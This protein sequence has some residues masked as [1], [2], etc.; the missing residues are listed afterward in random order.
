[1]SSGVAFPT[2]RGIFSSSGGTVTLTFEDGSTALL[3]LLASQVYPFK[4]KSA[5]FGTITDLSALY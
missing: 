5:A 4:C 2:C 3:T 1:V